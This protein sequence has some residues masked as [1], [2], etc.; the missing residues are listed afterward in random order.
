MLAE[1]KK[2][3]QH[4]L[5]YGFG[6]LMARAIGFFMIPLYTHYLTPR[7]YGTLELIDLTGYI[8]GY[9][10]GLG[11]DQSVVRYFY[12]YD[13]PKDR[14]TV[15]STA[16]WFNLLWSALLVAILVPLTQPLS[17]AI[18]GSRSYAPLLMLSWASLFVG[19]IVGLQRSVLRAQLRSLPFMILSLANT[20]VAVLLN[21]YFVAVAHI[22][23]RGI[24][25]SGIISSLLVGIYLW[26]RIVPQ[27]GLRFDPSKL[28]PMLRFGLPF[29]PGGIFAFV[30]NW[31]DRYF[32]RL[33]SSMEAVGLYGLGYKMGMIVAMLVSVPFSLIWNAYIFEL[34][35]RE[36]ARETYARVATYFIFALIAV[37]LGISVFSRELVMVM[38]DRS[39][40]GAAQVIPVITSAMIFMC[41]DNVFQVGLLI[42]GRTGFLSIAKG[43]AAAFN[44]VLNVLL[45][46]K[47]GAMGAAWS[48]SLSFLLYA[49][50]IYLASQRVYPIPFE[51]SRLVKLGVAAVLVYVP[52]SL[53]RLESVG[54]AVLVKAG[55]LLLYPVLLIV[56][57]FLRPE[58][59]R[60]LKRRLSANPG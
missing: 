31:S 39:Y 58:E 17:V 29:V 23:V 30:L 2:L 22:G 13:D 15:V 11:L 46:P 6:V 34:E 40:W 5:I 27:V 32:L 10:M 1:L 57:G 35:K 42:R 53:L 33:Y 4:T 44:V 3:G 52:A 37:A 21:I 49:T 9:L 47:Y 7:D 36:H 14:A 16:A 38:A 12:M 56:M 59:W 54:L 8:L 41:S 26:I 43:V 20:L 48:T 28:G 51:G 55:I 50:G 45:I 18:F 19:S 60:F 25:Y 24:I